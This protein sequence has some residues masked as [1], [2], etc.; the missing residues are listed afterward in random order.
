MVTRATV[1]AS[2]RVEHSRVEG[3]GPAAR[4][5]RRRQIMRVAVDLV[6]RGGY[7]GLQMRQVADAA[8]VSTRTLYKHFPSKEHLILAALIEQ[9]RVREQFWGNDRPPGR[10]AAQRVRQTMAI[11][12]Q[13]LQAYPVLASAMAKALVCGQSS[14][15]P[16]L[17]EFRDAMIRAIALAIRPSGPT[18]ADLTLA[19][20]LQRIWLTALL[21]WSSG[22]EPPESVGQA[23]D[24]AAALLLPTG[25][26]RGS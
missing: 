11:P 24:E 13:A 6:L 8:R 16:L 20:A 4:E 19:R 12:T 15:I 10:T 21:A 2:K 1:S 14:V 5:A 9:G 22:I 17:I 3:I 25:R 7:D 18:E 23:I 26:S